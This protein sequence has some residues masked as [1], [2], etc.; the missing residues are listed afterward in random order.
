MMQPENHFWEK[1][2]LKKLTLLPPTKYARAENFFDSMEKST[3]IAIYDVEKVRV[4]NRSSN[5][6]VSILF[7]NFC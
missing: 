6:L 7:F 2:F 5:L 4:D 3:R 1:T